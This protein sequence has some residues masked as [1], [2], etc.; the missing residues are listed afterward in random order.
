[1]AE[2]NGLTGMRERVVDAG[3]QLLLS[4]QPDDHGVLHLQ[5]DVEL[6]DEQGPHA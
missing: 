1:V 5:I 3:G 4:C 6:P 2:G